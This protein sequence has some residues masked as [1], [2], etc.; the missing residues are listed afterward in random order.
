MLERKGISRLG[1]IVDLLFAVVCLLWADHST[2]F[3]SQ[4]WQAIALLNTIFAALL[5]LAALLLG[6]QRGER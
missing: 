2:G 1:I 3:V 4:L 6:Y 5:I